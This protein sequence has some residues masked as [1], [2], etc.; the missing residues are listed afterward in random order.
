M[1]ASNYPRERSNKL[2][3]SSNIKT[4]TNQTTEVTLI[5]YE[6]VTSFLY[7][8]DNSNLKIKNIYITNGSTTAAC[9]F[10]LYL[11]KDIVTITGSAVRNAGEEI[12]STSKHYFCTNLVLPVG[13]AVGFQE[14]IFE[15]TDFLYHDLCI[16]GADSGTVGYIT[17]NIKN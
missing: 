14:E 11:K 9:T 7:G 3:Q 2:D 12:T 13:A 8:N 16:I 4:T 15:G 6:E 5:S 10:S 17:I 1:V